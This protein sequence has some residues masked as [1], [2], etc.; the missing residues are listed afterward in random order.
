[1]AE[2]TWEWP[3]TK[4][5]PKFSG[6]NVD[7]VKKMFLAGEAM[8]VNNFAKFYTDECHYQFGNFPVARTPQEIIDA[9]AGFIEKCEGLHHSIK[10]IWETDDGA[11]ICQM[12]VTYVGHDGR[13]HTL[14][15]C[16]TFKFEDDKVK[17]LRI[18]MDINPL[19]S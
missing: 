2:E 6:K 18:Y 12:E 1:M 3:H 10:N 8:N 17:E 15:C 11:L 14:P 19:F 16:N 9:S 4:K 5:W 7:I 13:V